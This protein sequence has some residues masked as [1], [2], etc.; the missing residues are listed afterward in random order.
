MVVYNMGLEYYLYEFL[1]GW[2]PDGEEQWDQEAVLWTIEWPLERNRRVMLPG[3]FDTST[4]IHYIIATNKLNTVSTMVLP[5]EKM[6]N[7][8]FGWEAMKNTKSTK[9]E[10]DALVNVYLPPFRKQIDYLS[11]RLIPFSIFTH[12]H[13]GWTPITGKRWYGLY[14]ST[15]DKLWVTVP[16]LEKIVNS[17]EN[18]GWKLPNVEFTPAAISDV[19][20][21]I[22]Y[23]HKFF[24]SSSVQPSD[25]TLFLDNLASKFLPIAYGASGVGITKAVEVW[26]SN[27][28][29]G[30]QGQTAYG[31]YENAL[32]II[33]KY[34]DAS[35]FKKWEPYESRELATGKPGGTDLY[36]NIPNAP[37]VV[38]GV[39]ATT[40]DQSVEAMGGG[41]RRRRKS[42]K[43]RRVSKRKVSKRKGTKRRKNKKT[44][45]RRR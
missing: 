36:R 23:I 30:I 42:T 4:D 34:D 13:D 33:D 6:L 26:D 17:L 40:M 20:E 37:V 22:K 24:R 8:A 2:T 21:R 39:Y 41:K 9:Q 27:V 7:M 5:N 31:V 32:S 18:A 11:K 43:R 45:R 10:V 28:E 44:K 25:E 16:G 35:N 15:Y 29:R 38:S 1:K 14:I 19:A 3:F 12:Y